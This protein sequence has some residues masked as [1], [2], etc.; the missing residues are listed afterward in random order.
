MSF[1]INKKFRFSFLLFC[2]LFSLLCIFI[3]LGYHTASIPNSYLPKIPGNFLHETHVTNHPI[4]IKNQNY[5]LITD[6]TGNLTITSP[7]GKVII[8]GLTYFSDPKWGLQDILSEKLNDSVIQ[9]QGKDGNKATVTLLLITHSYSPAIDVK[10]KTVYKSKTVVQREALVLKFSVPVSEVYSKNTK[11]DTTNFE[12]EYW[13]LHEGVRFG[14][15]ETSALIYHT[16]FVSSL[17]LETEKKLLFVNLDYYLDHPCIKMTGGRDTGQNWTDLSASEYIPG[18][19]RDNSFTINIGDIPRVTAR[20]MLVPYGFEAGYVFTEHADGGNIKNQRALYFGS[21]DIV[22]SKDATGGFIG[23]KIPVTKSVFYTGAGDTLGEAIKEKYHDTLLV[24]FLDQIYQTGLYDICLHTPENLN[25][26]REVLKEAMKYMK[27]RYYSLSWIDH[28]FYDGQNKESFVA[29]GLDSTS[30]YYAA[31]LWAKY[32]VR[33]FWSPAFELIDQNSRISVSDELKR[34]HFYNAY[35]I[36]LRHYISSRDLK[37]LNYV[38][39]FDLLSKRHAY[40]H[41]LNTP[42]SNLNNSLPTP[43]YWQHPTRTKQFYSWATTFVYENNDFSMRGVEQEKTQLED[44]IGDRG[45]LINHEY[46]VR[47]T[48]SNSFINRVEGKLVINPY[49]DK[50]LEIMADK[51]DKGELYITT[52]KDLLGYWIS[53]KDISFDYLPNGEIQV[54]NNNNSPVKGLSIILKTEEVFVD[55]HV[56]L[57]KHLGQETIVWFDIAANSKVKILVN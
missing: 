8:S 48:G 15:N 40:K 36:L 20:L 28:G 16:P 33:Y 24:N 26:S 7:Q 57:M 37:K 50:I 3:V 25:S 44:L 1:T 39:A 17:Q 49:F 32:D 4:E 13:L 38:Q 51:R 43:L 54:N 56:P 19:V 9:I 22:N 14:T 18:S 21:E 5:V 35:V 34:F 29:E 23:H 53:L 30:K 2:F 45:V 11:I 47:D 46:C 41:G 12:S 6:V 42:K 55:G 31:D 27:E 52:I 10:I